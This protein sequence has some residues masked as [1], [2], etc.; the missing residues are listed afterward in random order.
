[1]FWGSYPA[2]VPGLAA[3]H[4]DT[5]GRLAGKMQLMSRSEK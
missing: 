5:F 2:R 4:A 1:M 3:S